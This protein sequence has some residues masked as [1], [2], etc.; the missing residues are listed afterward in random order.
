[1]KEDQVS[2]FEKGGLG[3]A[4]TPEDWASF[5]LDGLRKRAVVLGSGARI[6]TTASKTIHVPRIT[7]DAEVIWANELEDLTATEPQGDDLILTPRKV[8][9]VSTL[10]NETVKDSSPAALDTA[11]A[12][13]IRAIAGAVDRALLT[14]TGPA[15]KQPTGVATLAVPQVML[16]NGTTPATVNYEGLVRGAGLVRNAGGEPDVAYV[17][18]SDWTLLQLQE[19]NQGRPLLQDTSEGPAPVVAGL[20]IY[21]AAGLTAGTALIAEA[22]QIVVALREDAT[23][24]VSGDAAFD[25]DGTKVRVI[26]R[27]DVG[28][29]DLSGLAIIR[30]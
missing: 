14:G 1:V 18:T 16:A 6:I 4:I 22:Q 10:S 9:N 15:N 12:N 21:P 24:A 13:I 8:G 7:S 2:I 19:D 26:A 20:R 5:V 29:N 3:A 17:A 25:T 28:V 27:V 30:P 23:V 11:G